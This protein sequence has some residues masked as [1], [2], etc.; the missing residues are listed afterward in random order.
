M[1]PRAV[2]FI[3]WLALNAPDARL[4]KLTAVRARARNRALTAL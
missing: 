3:Q 1:F 4:L 2:P